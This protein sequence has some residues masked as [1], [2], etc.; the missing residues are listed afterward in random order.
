MDEQID[1]LM[2]GWMVW[3]VDG[4]MGGWTDEWM[5]RR[6]NGWAGGWKDGYKKNS[7]AWD[8]RLPAKLVAT[9]ED[10]VSVRDPY[11]RILGF[12]DQSRYFLFQVAPQL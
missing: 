1:E 5:N 4:W 6:M 10:R 9:F 11:G 12:L 2:G 7:V 8:R 3:W